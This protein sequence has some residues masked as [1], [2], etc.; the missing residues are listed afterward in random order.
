MSGV[1]LSQEPKP[2][3]ILVQALIRRV[4]LALA[5]LVRD[6]WPLELSLD[7]LGDKFDLARPMRVVAHCTIPPNPEDLK[8]PADAKRFPTEYLLGEE[9]DASDSS[10]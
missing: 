5:P 9:T 7:V 1:H 8:R 6:G 10:L 2:Q 3:E 4:Q